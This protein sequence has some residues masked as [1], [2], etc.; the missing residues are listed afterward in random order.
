MKELSLSRMLELDGGQTDFADF[1]CGA[2][3]VG[4]MVLTVQPMAFWFFAGKTLALC[5]YA[6]AH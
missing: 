5:A 4:Q 6:A 1:A 2:A 3:I